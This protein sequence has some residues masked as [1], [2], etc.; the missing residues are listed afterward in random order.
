MSEL[1]NYLIQDLKCTHNI[2][3][4]DLENAVNVYENDGRVLWSYNEKVFFNPDHPEHVLITI[5]E[6]KKY[7]E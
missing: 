3:D 4:V 1:S 7:F 5:A 6:L 2:S